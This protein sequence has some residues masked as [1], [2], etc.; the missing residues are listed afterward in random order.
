VAILTFMTSWNEVLWPLMVVRNRA[1]MTMPQIVALFSIGG[2][3]EAQLGYLLAAA[4]LLSVPVIVAYGFFQRYFIES[5]SAT[6]LK[7]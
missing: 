2:E 3:A 5:L 6:G 4:T 1:L 7:G